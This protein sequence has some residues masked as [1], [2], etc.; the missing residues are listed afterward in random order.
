MS[1]SRIKCKK[2]PEYQAESYPASECAMC[3]YVWNFIQGAQR[4]MWEADCKYMEKL[5]KED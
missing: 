3:L 1:D 4:I 2:H 5:M